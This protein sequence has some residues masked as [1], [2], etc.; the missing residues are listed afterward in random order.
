M[1][2][3]MVAKILPKFLPSAKGAALPSNSVLHLLITENS[4]GMRNIMLSF[5]PG[6]N[7]PSLWTFSI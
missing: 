6:I 2:G 5:F 4:I 7:T 1:C 3:R